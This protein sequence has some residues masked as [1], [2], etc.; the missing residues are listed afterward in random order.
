MEV[1]AK[2]YG[3]VVTLDVKN[4]FDSAQS[5]R[6]LEALSSMEVQTYIRRIIASY[7]SDRT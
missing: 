4:A 3:A 1:E 6:I 5:G 7:F 2:Q